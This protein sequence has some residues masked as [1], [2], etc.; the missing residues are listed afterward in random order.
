M[1]DQL[2]GRGSTGNVYLGY[3]KDDPKKKVAVKAVDT[4]MVEN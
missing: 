4:R 1:E 2:L 3:H